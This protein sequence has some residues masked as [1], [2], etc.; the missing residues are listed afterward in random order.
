MDVQ[1]R[2]LYS[3]CWTLVVLAWVVAAATLG[4]LGGGWIGGVR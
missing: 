3:L 1:E 4:L 2:F